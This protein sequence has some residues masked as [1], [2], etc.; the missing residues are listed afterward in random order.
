VKLYITFSDRGYG[1]Y[2]SYADS[3]DDFIAELKE[4]DFIKL[5]SKI[6]DKDVMFRCDT[7][8]SFYEADN[9]TDN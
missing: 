4:N 5:Y 8:I 9:E 7:I 6:P 1:Y 3:L 2:Q